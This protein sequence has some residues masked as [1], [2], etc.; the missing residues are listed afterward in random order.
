MTKAIEKGS[1]VN[2]E[3][4]PEYGVGRVLVVDTFVTR[5][6]FPL[7]GLRIY[8]ADDLSRL[9]G[10]SAPSTQDIETLDRKEA[11]LAKGI[12]DHLP[13]PKEEI[14]AP[15]KKRAAKKAS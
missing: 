14:V 13:R 11:N 6:L 5:V 4:H 15:K 7:G 8:R 9:K 10:V 1:F 3:A 12:V 2:A